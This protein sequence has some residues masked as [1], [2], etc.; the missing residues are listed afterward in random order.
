M[1]ARKCLSS[2][3]MSGHKSAGP[4]RACV[5]FADCC[6]PSSV[7]TLTCVKMIETC[8]ESAFTTVSKRYA[9]ADHFFYFGEDD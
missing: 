6:D 8:V 1:W 2:M 7:G 9:I 5:K 4:L 3:G